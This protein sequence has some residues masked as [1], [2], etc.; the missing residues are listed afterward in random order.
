MNTETLS[1]EKKEKGFTLVEL[2]IV[3]AILGSLSV[4]VLNIF[5]GTKDQADRDQTELLLKGT[6]AGAIDRYKI[7]HRGKLP[8]TL[9]GLVKD[10][11]LDDSQR[12][13]VWGTEIKYEVKGRQ[14]QLTSAGADGQIGTDDDIYHPPVTK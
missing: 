10:G 12:F 5:G 1:I 2:M 9:Q 8:A 14:Y 11:Y 13:D 6:V 7:Q 4:L 3:I